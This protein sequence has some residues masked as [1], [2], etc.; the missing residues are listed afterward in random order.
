MS[1]Y[2]ELLLLLKDEYS[3][4]P[5]SDNEKFVHECKVLSEC[6]VRVLGQTGVKETQSRM[7]N[8][9]K[10]CHTNMADTQVNSKDRTNF[11]R[12]YT[13]TSICIVLDA[14]LFQSG[15]VEESF[16]IRCVRHLDEAIVYSG[17]PE[18]MDTVQGLITYIQKAHLPPLQ[19]IPF[20]DSSLPTLAHSPGLPAHGKKVPEMQEPDLMAFLTRHSKS[21]FVMRRSILHW[22]ALTSSPWSSQSY[23][24]TVS[25]RG[26]VVPVE[27]G[28]DYRR[29]DWNQEMMPW[30]T[31]LSQ[32]D[33]A[34]EPLV[35]LA[36]HSLLSQFPKL[37]ED[38]T[39]PDLVYYEPSS[40]H[41]AYEPPQ[42]E[43][44]LII[45]AWFGPKGTISPAH[46]VR[47]HSE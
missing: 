45:N 6:L 13:D 26:R 36:Q 42:N 22:P 17:A 34:E 21:P 32:V 9:L 11:R 3:Q 8:L 44:K 46:Q 37:A 40:D 29:D 18:R 31:F 16:W 27:I 25:G 1:Q 39:T 10:E 47:E 15:T 12:L 2:R 20:Q 30:E 24:L 35:Y 38:I 28:R 41:P 7:E 43:D 23:L 33:S 19:N 4:D 14:I 5:F